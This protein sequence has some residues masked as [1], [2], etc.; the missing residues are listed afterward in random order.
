MQKTRMH[1]VVAVAITLLALGAIVVLIPVGMN[2]RANAFAASQP[3]AL[4]VGSAF[5]YQGLLTEMGSPANGLYDFEFKVF[6]SPASGSQ[7]GGAVTVDDLSVVNGLFS[8]ALDFGSIFDGSERYL[9][10]GVRDGASAGA[11]ET[12]S[13]RQHITAAPY[14]IYANNGGGGGSAAESWRLGVSVDG[15][16]GYA[17]TFGRAPHL[18]ASYRSNAGVS[19]VYFVFPAASDQTTILAAD[20]NLLDRSGTYGGDANL[21][22]EIRDFAGTVQHTVTASAVDMEAATTGVWTAFSLSG[23]AADLVI[24]PGEYLVAHVNF[25]TGPSGDLDVKAAF[26][27][28][29]AQ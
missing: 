17:A 15:V 22:L 24:A 21:T 6:D 19:D 26:D 3:N 4:L 20:F 13:P 18:T 16:S 1:G 12:L 2:Q 5:S 25:S 27:I 9:E 11:Y 10:I 28:E 14:A 8:A 29:V 7:V 23:S